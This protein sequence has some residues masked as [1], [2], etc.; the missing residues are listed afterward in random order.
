MSSIDEYTD[1]VLSDDDRKFLASLEEERGLFRQIGDTL[2][3]P[4]GGW[5]KFIMGVAVILGLTLLYCAWRFFTAPNRDDLLFWGFVTLGALMIQGFIK[6]WL[7]NRA[8]TVSLMRELKRLRLHI[9][10]SNTEKL[11]DT[12]FPKKPT[13]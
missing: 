1:S 12:T 4:L 8:N 9:A 3:G 2:S 7:Y 6:E 10:M 11:T 5:S 13:D